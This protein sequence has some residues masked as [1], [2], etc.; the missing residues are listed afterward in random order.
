MLGTAQPAQADTAAA[1]SA[2]EVTITATRQEYT[3]VACSRKTHQVGRHS[4]NPLCTS[5][6]SSLQSGPCWQPVTNHA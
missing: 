6:R 2:A 1:A 3:S 4:V 5:L